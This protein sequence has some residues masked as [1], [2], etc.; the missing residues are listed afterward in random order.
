MCL[1]DF[2]VSKT[3]P[4][5]QSIL[6]NCGLPSRGHH[7]QQTAADSSLQSFKINEH[8]SLPG[9]GP[10]HQ[11]DAR[12]S[13]DSHALAPDL[14]GLFPA[15]QSVGAGTP[16]CAASLPVCSHLPSLAQRTEI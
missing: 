16:G 10:D 2:G 13:P 4:G 15:S 14:V 9:L 6:L 12:P 3:Q 7:R 5:A 11:Q 1:N 8:H